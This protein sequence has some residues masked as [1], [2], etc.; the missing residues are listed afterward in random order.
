MLPEPVSDENYVLFD[1]LSAFYIEGR[2]TDY[3]RKLSEYLTQQE[4]ETVLCQTREVF[5][6]LLTLKP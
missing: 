4:A 1:K 6:W 5:T 2:Y 3:K